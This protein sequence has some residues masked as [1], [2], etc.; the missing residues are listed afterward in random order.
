ML[1]NFKFV[2]LA[3]GSLYLRLSKLLCLIGVGILSPLVSVESPFIFSGFVSIMDRNLCYKPIKE[4]IFD[5]I[6]PKA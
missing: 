5:K 6:H 2:F 4:N 1:V 3:L